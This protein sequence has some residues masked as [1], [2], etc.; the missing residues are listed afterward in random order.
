MSAVDKLLSPFGKSN[1]SGVDSGLDSSGKKDWAVLECQSGSK[2]YDPYD[3]PGSGA[4]GGDLGRG[5][6]F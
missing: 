3:V 1:T 4:W 6:Q 5:I 2:P